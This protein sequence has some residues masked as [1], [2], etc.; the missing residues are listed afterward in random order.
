MEIEYRIKSLRLK[1][2]Q[3]EIVKKREKKRNFYTTSKAA[4]EKV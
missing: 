4:T 3:L 1:I 2:G